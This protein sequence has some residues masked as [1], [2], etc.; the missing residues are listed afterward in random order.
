MMEKKDDGQ[1]SGCGTIMTA[2]TA[3][4]GIGGLSLKTLE[5][6]RQKEQEKKVKDALI[7]E[8]VKQQD[9]ASQ[10]QEFTD[11]VDKISSCFQMKSRK[12]LPLTEMIKSFDGAYRG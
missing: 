3:Y 4:T 11:L 5:M 10:I 7:M 9:K 2:S 8:S 12:A 6:L 1:L